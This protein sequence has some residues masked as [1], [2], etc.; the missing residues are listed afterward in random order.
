MFTFPIGFFKEGIVIFRDGFEFAD[1]WDETVADLNP[2]PSFAT[3]DF[4]EGYEFAEGWSETVASVPSPSFTTATHD[5]TFD[6][7][8]DGT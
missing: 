6:S 2:Q 8:W 4:S 5:E 3:A 7:G 1:G